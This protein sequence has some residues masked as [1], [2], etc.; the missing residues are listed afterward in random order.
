MSKLWSKIFLSISLFFLSFSQVFAQNGLGTA[1]VDQGAA[2]FSD[3]EG[4]FSHAVKAL[5]ELAG[6]VLFI[7]LVAGGFKFLLS[8]GDQKKL[9]S[10]KGTITNAIVGL[11][12]IVVAYLILLTIQTFT[13]VDVTQFTVPSGQ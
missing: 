4:I 13:G 12:V 11:V 8:G 6:A 1:G 7:M 5:V 3:L 9:E 2:S 10:A